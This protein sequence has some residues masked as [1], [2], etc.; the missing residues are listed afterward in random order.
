M[1]Y[2]KVKVILIGDSIR[3]VMSIN[4]NKAKDNMTRIRTQYQKKH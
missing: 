2:K 1:G 4:F 3:N